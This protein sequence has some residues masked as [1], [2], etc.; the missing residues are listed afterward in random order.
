MKKLLVFAGLMATIAFTTS[1]THE[2]ALSP[3][4]NFTPQT[5][6]EKAYPNQTGEVKQ[7]FFRNAPISF[8]QINGESVFQ[9]DI[10]LHDHELSDEPVT[11]EGTGRTRS[12]A[13]W[14]N[15]IVYYTIDPALPNPQ[16]VY[17]AMAHWEAN[18]SIRFV[19]RTTQ[20]GY[21]L[22]RNSSG[23]SANVGYSG[24]LQYVNLGSG[25]SVGNTIHEIGHAVGLWHEHTRVDRN[26]HITINYSN[27]VTGTEY[28]FDTYAAQGYDGFDY[29]NTLDLNS[30][31]MYGPYDFSKNGL[32]TIT[33]KDGSLF[34][35]QR[36]GLSPLDIATV[37]AM[38]P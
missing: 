29:G 8:Q 33:R 35:I 31:M 27:I 20:R 24:S 3:I 28:N 18:T 30:V 7:A 38:Y 19:A 10:I 21:V 16:R 14:P 22:F 34:S 32:P 2:N 5:I 6:A 4:S 36:N 13:K 9:N 25:C 37:Q 12:T 11:G 26:N 1:C 23:C 17:D 15:K